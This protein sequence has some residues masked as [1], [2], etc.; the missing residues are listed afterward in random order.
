MHPQRRFGKIESIFT[1]I[2]N[3]NAWGGRESRSGPGSSL[4]ETSAVRG[5]LPTLLAELNIRSLLDAPCGDLNWMSHTPL[6]LDSYIGAD[7][8]RKVVDLNNE[9]FT[10]A[11]RRFVHFDILRDDL[12]AADAILCR[13]GL[14]HFS[15]ADVKKALAGFRQS[16]ATYLIATTYRDA[17]PSM[18]II[19]GEW[20]PLD[21]EAAPFSLPKPLRLVPENPGRDGID[22]RKSLGVWKLCDFPGFS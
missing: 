17:G 9:K 13:D 15:D 7:V 8:V 21:L 20:Q 2:Y 3:D 16:R 11:M 14:V 12:P 22:S 10:S 6:D 1:R 18:N 4:A 19:T 5:M